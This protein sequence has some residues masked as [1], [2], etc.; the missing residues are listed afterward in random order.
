[1]SKKIIAVSA[2]IILAAIAIVGGTL[3]WFT[4]SDTATNVL[5]TGNI[6]I[7]LT[8]TDIS[9]DEAPVTVE[10]LTIGDIMPGDT[11]HKDPTI[12]NTSGTEAAY[13]RAQFTVTQTS[14]TGTGAP[15]L[16][17]LVIAQIKAEIDG[18]I[19]LEGDD[20]WYYLKAALPATG[21]NSVKLF[22]E[23]EFPG[24]TFKDEY[25][26]AAFSIVIGAQATQVE[27]QTAPTNPATYKSLG[28]PS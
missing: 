4:A 5:T 19:W 25:Q 12:T 22:S 6:S 28:W 1:M 16:T 9:G 10:G 18:T 2:A 24:A 26:N 8:E 3:A 20:G 7:T 11:I 13:I 21:A 23:I 17:D 27:N 15:E 14:P